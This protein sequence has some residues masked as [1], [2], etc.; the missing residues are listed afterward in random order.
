M[1]QLELDLVVPLTEQLPL[2]LDFTP[3]KKFS[4]DKLHSTIITSNVTSVP[5]GMVLTSNSITNSGFVL[6][7]D[8]NPVTVYT[9]EKMP[10]YR[11]TLYNLLGIKV[12]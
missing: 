4:E 10:W 2:D 12:K 3:S 9:E 1:T 5:T 6:H 8:K 7:L 11:K